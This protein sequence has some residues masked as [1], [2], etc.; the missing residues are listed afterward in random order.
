MPLKPDPIKFCAFCKSPMSRKIYPAGSRESIPRFME[1]KFCT[2]ECMG[3][4][5]RELKPVACLTCHTVFQPTGR[6]RKY[7]KPACGMKAKIVRPA[8][9]RAVDKSRREARRKTHRKE[10][11]VCQRDYRLQVHH[12]DENPLNNSPA[13]L[14]VLCFW[15]HRKAHQKQAATCQICG[16]PAKRFKACG[17][18]CDMHYRRFRRHGDPLLK[19][20][21]SRRYPKP[22]PVPE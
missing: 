8:L 5:S 12:I 15:C 11:K 3:A 4:D 9:E 17:T 7:C 18:L 20:T 22:V 19:V 21:G 14:M 1:R 2:A 6:H 13:N 16:R 10:C